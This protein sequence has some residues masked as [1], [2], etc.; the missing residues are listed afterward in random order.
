VS[1]TPY[2][3]HG[4]IVIYHGDCRDILP[5]VWFGVDTLLTDPPY[6][7]DKADWD[8]SFPHWLWSVVPPF[9]SAA[10]IMP[11][12]WNLPMM[13]MAFG[14]LRYKWT[15]CA[16][17]VNGMTR[18]AVGFGNWIPCVLYAAEHRSLHAKDSDVR[19]FTVGGEPKPDHPSPKP[20]DP[21]KWFLSRLGGRCVLDPFLGSGTTLLA[22]KEAG[23]AAIGIDREER[24]CEIAA[25]RLS[26]EVLPLEATA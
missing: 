22:A 12:V 23:V 25:K 3:D 2:Y 8:S 7:I 20:L 9:I 15:L 19:R 10:G 4:G 21:V 26:Q 6:G 1:L 5:D 17:L 16:H 13:P 14:G 18:G 24:Y 11:G